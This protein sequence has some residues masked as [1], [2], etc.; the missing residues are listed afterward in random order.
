MNRDCTVRNV[1]RPGKFWRL[2]KSLSGGY[3]GQNK[4]HGATYLYGAYSV[5]W[6]LG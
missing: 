6:N 3:E 4:T 5:K 1:F 2:G